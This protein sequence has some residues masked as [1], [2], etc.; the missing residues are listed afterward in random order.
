MN[1]AGIPPAPKLQQCSVTSLYGIWAGY[2]SGLAVFAYSRNWIALLAWLVLVP[3]G[4]LLHI[5]FYPH[6]SSFFGYGQIP[7]DRLPARVERAP[8]TVTYYSAL[9]CPFCPIVL[10]RLEALQKP[11]GFTL[12][13]VNLSL[14]PQF[15][16]KKGIRSV[17]VVEVG[18]KRLIGNA[19]SEQL[20]ELIGFPQ[21]ALAVS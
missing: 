3:F 9:G 7:A 6:F 13:T 17:P 18:G 21:A 20:A 5:R 8:V 1:A 15:G 16:A 19:T 11:M 4:K 14:H 2:A 12:E 10:R